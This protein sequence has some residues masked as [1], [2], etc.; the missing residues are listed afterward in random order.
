MRK[1]NL[2][3]RSIAKMANVS[4]MT[5]SRALNDNPH[6]K[7]ETKKRILLLARNLKFRLDPKARNLATKRSFL[8]G[9]VVSDIRNPF[10]AELAGGIEDTTR[11]KGYSILFCSTDDQPN[12][13][14]HYVNKM[15]DA[16]VEGLIFASARLLE[17]VIEELINDR[18][19]LV[20][21]NRKLKGEAYNYVVLDNVKGAYEL[22][23]HL[24][25]N[26]YRKIAL[27][28][29]PSNLS[30]GLDR[31]KGYQ[32]ALIDHQIRPK[33]QYVF[34]GPF[35]SE[36]GYEGAK[37]F[38]GMKSRPEAI[39]AGND[40]IAM[41]AIDAI[42]EA[43]MLIPDD[44]ALV[45]FDDTHF[46]SNKRVNLTTV[47]QRQ[48][49]MGRMSAQILINYIER[50]EIDYIH[51]VVMEPRLVI[52]KTCGYPIVKKKGLRKVNAR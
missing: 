9:L 33:P 30:T 50:K 21:T 17:P 36:T 15:L 18:F 24:I 43:K 27:L 16:G 8:I 22:T 48:Y 47:S 19:P 6:V 32:K 23:K 41:G 40:Y 46:A 44:I 7:D 13:V 42:E 45:G 5:V 49:E 52:R 37:H 25:D 29:G 38:L 51:K 12:G 11:K 10:Y 14:E 1:K 39:F 28:N 20:L 3:I 26:G 2:T 34:Q 31:Q 4:H 35:T